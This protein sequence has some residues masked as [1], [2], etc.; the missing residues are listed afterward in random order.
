MKRGRVTLAQARK[1]ARAAKQQRQRKKPVPRAPKF[2]AY[3]EIGRGDVK[4][5]IERVPSNRL[6]SV[7]THALASLRKA[8]VRRIGDDDR[9]IEQVGGYAPLDVKD[10]PYEQGERP[11]RVGF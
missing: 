4:L 2:K 5:H 9:P 8:G 3:I 1:A 10:D 7:I 6:S 11:K